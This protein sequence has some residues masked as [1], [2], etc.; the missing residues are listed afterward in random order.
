MSRQVRLA[1]YS[2]VV[3]STFTSKLRL[4]VSRSS[5]RQPCVRCEAPVDKRGMR[6][7]GRVGVLKKFSLCFQ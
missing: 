1:T 6:A 7:G 3:L 5:C 2:S 4:I